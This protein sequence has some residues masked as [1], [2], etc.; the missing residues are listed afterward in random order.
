MSVMSDAPDTK[1]SKVAATAKASP[2]VEMIGVS[3]W[4]PDSRNGSRIEALAKLDLRIDQNEAGAFLVLLGPSG[5]GKSTILSLISGLAPAD[6]GEVHVF[7]RL[8]AGPDPDSAS[9]PQAYTCFPW[10]TVIT[11]LPAFGAIVVAGFGAEQRRFARPTALGFSLAALGLTVLVCAGFNGASPDLQFVERHAWI[12]SSRPSDPRMERTI[13]I[14]SST[15]SRP[16]RSQSTHSSVEA[17]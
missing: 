7:G 12:P 3:K 1:P 5:C 16:P 10:L 13:P 8:V 4:F 14:C 6:E 11:A 2:I 9:V 15:K 17:G